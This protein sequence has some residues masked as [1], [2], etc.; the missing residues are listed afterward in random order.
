MMALV[1]ST[2]PTAL[3]AIFVLIAP[4]SA[5]AQQPDQA[6]V[7]ARIDDAVQ[8]R[9]NSVLGFT[10]IEHY[11]VFR[12]HDQ[13]HPAAEMTVKTTYRKGVGK[14]YEILSQ[15]GSTLV[16][17]FGL[18]PLLDNEKT[19]NEPGNVERSWFSSANYEMKLHPGGPQPLNGRSC[20][21]LDITARRKAPNMI[22]GTIWV[23]ASDG[24]LARIDGI[25]SKSPSPFA[26]TTHMMREYMNMD[27]FPMATH[28]RA[29]SSSFLFGHTVVS[30]DYSDYKL[31][32]APAR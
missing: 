13:T 1:R 5:P 19:V 23:D 21:V 26:G 10:D 12:G 4:A 9:Y 16:M 22:D 11:S 15:S 14:S 6:A 3:A 29:E 18:Q 8:H 20:Y 30:I 24:Q 17:H 2:A 25:A 27:G 28:A 7:I 32:I 31:Q